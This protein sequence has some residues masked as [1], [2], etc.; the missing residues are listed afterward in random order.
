MGVQT[1]GINDFLS[2]EHI[3]LDIRAANKLGVLQ[4]LARRAAEALGLSADSI[5]KELNKREELGS[6]GT[7]GG[8]AIPHAR[9]P[10]VKTPFGMFARLAQPVEF[11]AIDGEP[12]DLVFLLLLPASPT[13]EQL[14]ALAAV[15]RKLRDKRCLDRVRRAR[16]AMEIDRAVRE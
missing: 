8:T 3:L 2:P 14:N 1:V 4:E 5:S 15:A 13:G 7:G 10:Q 11:D 16:S 6:T 9:L 12:V